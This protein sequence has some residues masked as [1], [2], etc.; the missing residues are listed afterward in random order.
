MRLGR[1]A[2]FKSS[3]H[4]ENS[5][6]CECERKQ[7]QLLTLAE[8]WTQRLTTSLLEPTGRQRFAKSF[9]KVRPFN[10]QACS[11]H[12]FFRNEEAQQAQLHC[13]CFL[14]EHA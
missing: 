4:H 6:Q 11:A 7:L 3:E 5:A 9:H 2:I 10:D 13:S 8:G 14:D 12:G 1:R